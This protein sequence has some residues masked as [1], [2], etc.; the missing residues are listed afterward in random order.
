MNK[1]AVIVGREL[2]W[3]TT[4]LM[5]KVVPPGTDHNKRVEERNAG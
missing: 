3:T 2:E 5:T 1:S 4:P